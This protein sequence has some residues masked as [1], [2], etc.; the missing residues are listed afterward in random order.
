[1]KREKKR[2]RRKKKKHVHF[3]IFMGTKKS[4]R[5]SSAMV[6][7]WNFRNTTD[8]YFFFFLIR[9][10]PLLS[11]PYRS[12]C[13]WLFA[14]FGSTEIY[15][16]IYI[17]SRSTANPLDASRIGGGRGELYE[18]LLDGL[19]ELEDRITRDPRFFFIWRTIDRLERRFSN[20]AI[21]YGYLF[22]GHRLTDGPPMD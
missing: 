12:H 22:D 10:S 13:R 14:I 17:Y 1:M 7:Q 18:Y 5:A 21:S 20:R 8:V 3:V 2:R 15:I 11:P 6:E 4:C 9:Y 16:H 19:W